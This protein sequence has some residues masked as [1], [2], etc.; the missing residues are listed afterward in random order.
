MAT[1]FPP[2]DITG[3]WAPLNEQVI[4][5]IDL[6]PDDKLN[7]SPKPQLYNF[8]GILI[9]MAAA[10]HGW[11]ARDVQDGET[12]PDVLRE[13]QTKDGLKQQ[14]RLSWA[15]MERF[16]RDPQRLDAVFVDAFDGTRRNGHWFA[17]HGLEH[18]IHHRADIFHYLALLGV[19]HGDISTP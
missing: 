9:H 5:L 3:Y 13:G 11:M 12:T 10:R 18:D 6:I 17:Y 14:L 7:W 1:Q 16:L 15:R 19:E 4:A 2:L 8:K